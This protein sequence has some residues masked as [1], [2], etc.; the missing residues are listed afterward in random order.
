[1]IYV[2]AVIN[3]S[4]TC[5]HV[6][7]LV[8]SQRK[9]THSHR[10]LSFQALKQVYTEENDAQQMKKGI[11]FPVSVCTNDLFGHLSPQKDCKAVLR[12]GDIVKA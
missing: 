5:V 2:S 6:I 11:C 12:E 10:A 9:Q 8:L 3:L 7:L 1:M 4:I